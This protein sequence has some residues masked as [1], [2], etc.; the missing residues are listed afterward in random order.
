MVPFLPYAGSQLSSWQQS[1]PRSRRQVRLPNVA[2]LIGASRYTH[3]VASCPDNNAGASDRAGFIDAPVSG[4]AKRASRPTVAPMAERGVE[5]IIGVTRDPI[6]GPVIM[7]GIGGTLVEVLR[8][9]AFRAI[10]LSRAEADGMLEQLHARKILEG[11]RGAPPIDRAAMV[12]LIMTVSA[13]VQAHP[14]INELDLNPVIAHPS[15]CTVVDA[16]II[17]SKE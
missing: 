6:Y 5:V 17:L 16:R 8:D 9:V 7:F 4:P 3:T 1:G 15:G 11:V 12:D 13:I 10:P 14:E 2:P